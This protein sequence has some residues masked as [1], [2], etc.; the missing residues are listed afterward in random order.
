MNYDAMITAVITL[1]ANLGSAILKD[2]ALTD[3]EKKEYLD[4]INKAQE[5]VPEWK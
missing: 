5:L 2:D 4:R 1:L 3:E